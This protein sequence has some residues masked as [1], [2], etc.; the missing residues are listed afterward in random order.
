MVNDERNLQGAKIAEC[1]FEQ[2]PM[3]ANWGHRMSCEIL[4]EHEPPK[5]SE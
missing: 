1:G 2:N 5:S 3:P 4:Q